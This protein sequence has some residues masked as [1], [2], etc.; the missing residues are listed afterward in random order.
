MVSSQGN[1]VVWVGPRKVSGAT[2]DSPDFFTRLRRYTIL[3]FIF[4]IPFTYWD[5]WGISHYFTVSKMAGYLYFAIAV[6]DFPRSLNLRKIGSQTIILIATYLIFVASSVINYSSGL[7]RS[8][9]HTTL[10]QNI[11][12]F[13]LLASDFTRFGK[14]FGRRAIFAFIFSVSAL[15]S[16][17]MFGIGIEQNSGVVGEGRLVMFGTNPN[18]IGQNAALALVLLFALFLYRHRFKDQRFSALSLSL[19]PLLIFLIGASG[20]RGAL[21]ALVVG[22]LTLTVSFRADLLKRF[23]L[24][25]AAACGLVVV[26]DQVLKSEIMSKRLIRSLNNNDFGGRTDIWAHVLSIIGE[27]PVLGH[28]SSGFELRIIQDY[29]VYIDPHNIFLYVM[30]IGGLV[31]LGLFLIFIYR[32]FLSCWRTLI[33]QQDS[34][35]LVL[36]SVLL[37]IAFKSGGAI[38]N[39][40]MW[41]LMALI[42]AWQFFPEVDS[43][44]TLLDPELNAFRG[45]RNSGM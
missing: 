31:A 15:G 43:E 6:L 16:L 22:V 8:V 25:V 11:I 41:S 35:P 23:T 19:S 33:E 2:E 32:L 39:K 9:T 7:D 40:L 44:R 14:D 21:I 30:A 34:I 12:L 24:V 20:S 10:L 42:F 17:A 18:G 4:S 5:P 1:H 37:F 45:P 28:G 29:G 27:A 26:L 38:D 13:A 36:L 3:I